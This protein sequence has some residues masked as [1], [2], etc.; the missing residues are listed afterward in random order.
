MAAAESSGSAAVF[1]LR[2]KV[3][4]A[5]NDREGNPSGNV[6]YKSYPEFS[7]KIIFYVT[8][9]RNPRLPVGDRIG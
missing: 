6:C 5:L 7:G 2:V 1:W 8:E 9:L 3:I 4:G